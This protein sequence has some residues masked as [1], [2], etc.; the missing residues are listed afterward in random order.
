MIK[1]TFPDGSIHEFEK[2]VTGLDIAKH[3]SEGLANVAIAIEVNSQLKDLNTKITQDSNIKIIT[4]KDKEGVEIFRH[5]T[6]HLMAQAITIL[7]PYAKLTIGPIVDEG[8]Y[9][10]IDHEPFKPEDLEKIEQKMKELRSEK[11]PFERIE[12]SKEKALEMFKDND[13]KL[14][15]INELPETEPISIYKQGEFVDLCR[16]PHVLHTGKIKSFKLTKIAGAYWRGDAKNKQ[17]QRIYGISFPDKKEL[18]QY[19]H[20]REEAEKR[21]HNKVGRQMELFTS[22]DIV[23]QGLPLLMPKGA[24]IVQILQRWIEDEEEKRGYQLTKTPFM[25]KSDLYKVSGHWDHYKDGMFQI[26]S[27]ENVLA[28]RPMTCPFQFIIYNAK[29]HSYRDL[30]VRYNETSP[31]FRN[32]DSGEMHGL[33]RVRQFT[34]AEGHIICRPDQ[35]AYEFKEVVK[36]VEY[37]MK[38]LKIENEIWYRFSKWD[39]NNKKGKYIDNTAAWEGSQKAM[40]EILD[41]LK[42]NYV[43]VEGEAAF[44]GPKLDIQAKNVHGKEDTLITIQIDFALP[45]RFDMTYVDSDGSKKRPMVVHRSSI[46]CYE[47]TLALL[48]EH[49]AGKFPLWLSPVQVKILTVADRHVEYAEKLKQQFQTEGLRVELDHRAESIPKKVREAQLEQVNYILVVGD[50]ELE[51]NTVNIRTRDNQVHGE[52]PVDKFIEELTEEI[53]ER[54]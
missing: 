32:E 13:F 42:L 19:L 53:K 6:A 26:G 17:L 33:T 39:P 2:E 10:D 40:K 29:S 48:I 49:Y 5:S 11:I 35:L 38:T 21:D 23:G 7:Y 50:K 16:G 43:E 14:E 1:I 46:G 22:S 18:K 31:L 24:K 8:F 44:Y 9:Y 4:F 28:L 37:I 54:K 3:I 15:M 20:L 52:K 36:L 51:N 41:E 34:L 12:L 45:E 30:P 27:G 47:R 25:A